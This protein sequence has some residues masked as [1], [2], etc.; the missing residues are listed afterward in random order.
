[1]LPIPYH[2]DDEQKKTFTKLGEVRKLLLACLL[3][4]IQMQNGILGIHA[5]LVFLY[6]YSTLL[7]RMCTTHLAHFLTNKQD[8]DWRFRDSAFSGLCYYTFMRASG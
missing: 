7:Y 1:M 6:S 3:T 4:F 5:K 2:D 8:L